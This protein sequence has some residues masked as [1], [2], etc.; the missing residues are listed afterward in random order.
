MLLL[1]ML[2]QRAVGRRQCD[3]ITPNPSI[4]AC[5]VALDDNN[6]AR[7][8]VHEHNGRFFSARNVT[9]LIEV[10]PKETADVRRYKGFEDSERRY[11]VGVGLENMLR[12]IE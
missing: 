7:E 5:G 3:G 8:R 2:A 6:E 1:H 4:L 12:L 11:A 10:L 9:H